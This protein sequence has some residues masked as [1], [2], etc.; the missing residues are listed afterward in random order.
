[1]TSLLSQEP[2]G[3]LVGARPR[4]AIV[5]ERWGIDYCCGGR[6]SLEA[7]CRE[8][9]VDLEAVLRDLLE[10]DMSAPTTEETDWTTAPL[11]ELADHIVETHHAYLAEALPRLLG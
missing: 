7:A 6:K 1:M 4:R 9:A 11:G 3:L 10:S 8:K 2:V 5:F